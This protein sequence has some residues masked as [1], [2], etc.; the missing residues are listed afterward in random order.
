M[1]KEI[2]KNALKMYDGTLIIVSH[3]RDFLQGLTEKVYEFKDQNIVEHL[4]DI[5]DFLAVKKVLDFKEFEAENKQK[6]KSNSVKRDSSNKLDYEQKKQLDKDIKK[7]SN[8]IKNLERKVDGIE[9]ELKELDLQLSDPEKYKEL[10]AQSGFF[11]GYKKK[12]EELALLMKEWEDDLQLVEELKLKKD[13][14]ND[15]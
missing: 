2:L 9:T 8:K 10:S 12:Q 7:V 6:A 1:S 3:D 14:S 15:A 4:G 11:D 5:N 13:Q